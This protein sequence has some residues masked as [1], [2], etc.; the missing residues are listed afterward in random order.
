VKKHVIT[1][2]IVVALLCSCGYVE[3]DSDV[4]VTVPVRN[5]IGRSVDL[6]Q[7]YYS[8][9]TVVTTDPNSLAPESQRH[10]VQ[11][12]YHAPNGQ[13]FL[14]YPG[15]TRPVIGRW[16]VRSAANGEPILCYSYGQ[17]S[18]NPVTKQIGGGECKTGYE[19]MLFQSFAF[20]G[21]PFDL[22][23]GRL[24]FVIPDK[25]YYS[26]EDL[27]KTWGHDPSILN[28]ITNLSEI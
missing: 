3:Q 10:G 11:I 21:D 28:Y 27:M 5:Q 9:A 26:P 14:W 18:Y 16:E 19:A 4:S 15:N 25:D 24:P 1:G 17:N 2:V 12:E 22:A 23:S 20:V 6:L 8:G 7:Q 13:S